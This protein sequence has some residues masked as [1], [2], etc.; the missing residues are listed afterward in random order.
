MLNDRD[1]ANLALINVKR[2][3]MD[4]TRAGMESSGNLR[5]TLIQMRNDCEQ[6]QD[7]LGQLAIGKGWYMPATP[8][9]QSEKQQIVDFFRSAANEPAMRS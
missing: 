8:A 3:I 4:L 6:L 9:G 1:I 7:R 5:Q 2:S